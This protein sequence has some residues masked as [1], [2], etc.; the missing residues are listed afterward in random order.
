MKEADLERSELPAKSSMDPYR[1]RHNP[2][3]TVAVLKYHICTF[4]CSQ[5]SSCPTWL[6]TAS[7]RQCDTIPQ[8]S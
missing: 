4:S 1:A 2:L 8:H 5:Q 6:S 3:T 7:W